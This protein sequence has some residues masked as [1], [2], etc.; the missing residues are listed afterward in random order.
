ME[1]HRLGTI[2]LERLR[3]KYKLNLSEFI[4]PQLTDKSLFEFIIGVMLSQNTSDKNAIKA[5]RRLL[6]KYGDPLRPE[7]ILSKPIDE[8]IDAIRPAGMYSV[9]ARNIVHLARLFSNRGFEEELKNRI[10]RAS[11]EE[12]RKILTSLP[13][14]GIK[15]A[16]VILSQYF[17]IPAFPVDTHIRRIT[18][19]LGYV[20]SRSYREIS[21]WWM[22]ITPPEHYVE[23]HLLLITHG[24]RTCR[25]RNPLC[26]E[27]P[28]KDICRYAGGG[29][30]LGD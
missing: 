19:R 29:I 15:S 12:A 9:R 17:K 28:L 25:A 30:K 22:K 10:R 13:G 2:I 4:A 8:L 20:K 14:I 7:A 18:L 1:N 6:E 26:S 24:R 11:L 23:V 21:E 27:C 5:Y 16:D 3:K